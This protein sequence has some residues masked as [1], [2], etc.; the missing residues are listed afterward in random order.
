M[1]INSRLGTAQ[2]CALFV[3]LALIAVPAM[4]DNLISTQSGDWGAGATWGGSV[5]GPTDDVFIASGH[6]V[7]NNGLDTIHINSLSVSGILAHA[8]NS[9]T[10][11]NKIIL[12]ITNDCT[13][14]SGGKIDVTGLGYDVGYGPGVPS[15]SYAG[16]SYGGRGGYNGN[17]E[18]QLGE[19]YGSLVAPTN[20]GSGSYTWG[21]SGG[22]AV[23]ITAG[24][25]T[26]VDGGILANGAAEAV[27]PS[28]SYG[29]GSGGSVFITTA[30]LAGSGSV[31]ANGGKGVLAST[32]GAGGGGRVS[33]VLTSG[34][35]FGSVDLR[36]DRGAGT[37]DTGG[38]LGYS[39][40]GTVYTKT[41]SQPY[42]TVKVD[43]SGKGLF[44]PGGY[45][46]PGTRIPAG[47]TWQVDSV[48]LVNGGT[49]WIDDTCTLIVTNTS[50]STTNGY[51][52]NE[53]TLSVPGDFTLTSVT[54]MPLRGSTF[55][56]T[57]LTIDSSA[58]VSHIKNSTAEDWTLEL[59]VPGNLTIPGGASIDVD[60]VGYRHLQGP[61]R[62]VEVSPGY[63][64]GGSYG[65]RGGIG[66]NGYETGPTYGSISSPTNIGSGGG[67]YIGICN[68]G[69]AIKLTVGGTTSLDGTI[70]ADGVNIDANSSGGG[71][72]GSVWLTT[73]NLVG[74]G[75]ITADGGPGVT[76]GTGGAGGGGGRISVVLTGSDTFGSVALHAYGGVYPTASDLYDGAAGT[77]YKQTQNQVSGRG[78][79]I[80]DNRGELSRRN[81]DISSNV[82]DTVVGDVQFSNGATFDV[83]TN[84]SITVYGNWSN[85]YEF[86]ADAGGTVNLA[87]TNT[88]TVFGHT[89]FDTLICSNVS[90]RIN[91]QAGYTQ[92]VDN[93]FTFSGPSDTGL[94]LRS[95]AA[96][97]WG[98]DLDAG[99][100]QTIEYVDVEYSDARPG[101]AATAANSKDSGS[102]SNWVFSAGGVE[103]NIWIGAGGDSDWGNSGNWILGRS[104]LPADER[105]IISNGVYQPHMPSA[106]TFNNLEVWT[107]ATLSL[108]NFNLTV[109]NEAIV[110]GTITAAGGE[111]MTFS[112]NLT[113]SGTLTAVGSQEIYVGGDI[114]FTGGTFTEASSHVILNGTVAQSITSDGDS[115]ATL[116]ASNQSALVTFVD[117]VTATTYYSR[118]GDV[119]YGGNFDAT[120]F[121]VYSEAG[122]VTHTFEGGSTYTFQEMWLRG[123][124][125]KTQHLESAGT[126]NLNV[127]SVANVNNVNVEYSDA[128]TGIEIVGVNSTDGNNNNNWNFGPFA[129]WTGPGTDFHTASNWEPEVV[130]GASSDIV[131]DDADTCNVDSPAT[132][133]SA[134][135]GGVNASRLQIDN[136]FT[137]VSNVYVVANGTLEINDDPG[138]T[139][140][141][142]MTVSSGG[143]VAHKDNESTEE[144]RM[145]LTV[146]GD[147]TIA[148]GGKIDVTGLG[149]DVG[150]GPGVPSIPYAGGS[151]GGRGGY[152]SSTEVQLGETY[153]SLVAPT[154][155][156]SGS[157]TLG[158]SGGGAIRI[159]V[160]GT[161]TVNGGILANGAVTGE[162]TDPYGGGS[163]GSVFITTANF[164]GSG[165]VTANGALGAYANT[166]GA[167]GGG[168]VAVVLTSGST[169]GSVL[170]TADRGAGTNNTGG[171][172]AYSCAGTVYTKTPSQ[173]YGTVKVDNSGKGL[174]NPGGYL[175]PGT[176]IPAGDTWQVDS[177]ELV[178][179]GTLWIDDT[180]TLIVTNTSPSTTNGYLINEGTL[181]VPGDFVV[182]SVTLM[183][184]AGSVFSGLTN[185]TIDSSAVV[186]H[187]KNS[188]AEDWTLEM[189][190]PGNLTIPGGASID[191]DGLGYDKG[192][193][194]GKLVPGTPGY[195]TGASHGGRG[196][197]GNDSYEPGPT[198][199][200]IRSPT[201]IG[202]GGGYWTVGICNGGGAIKLTVGGTTSLDGTISAKGV[203]IDGNS[204]GGGS[205][206]SVWLTTSSLVGSGTIAADGGPG[207]TVGTGGAGGGGGRISVVL[208]G[209]D[210]FGSA[211]L[212]AYG[213]VYPT[214]SDLFDGAAGTVYKQTLSQGAG[215]GT[216]IVDNNGEV[217]RRS[218]YAPPETNAVADELIQAMIIVTNDNS[219]LT[220]STNI[221]VDDILVYTNADLVLGVYTMYVNSVEHHIDDISQSGAGGPTNGVDSYDQIVWQGA[222]PGMVIVVR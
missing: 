160:G 94:V 200:S 216:L 59:D 193:G 85:G 192:K 79:L 122:A 118:N 126:W 182:S 146:E 110:Q 8:D 148:A 129:V 176:R 188:T 186:S 141:N 136:A 167:G 162:D 11:A 120:M 163:G 123:T 103:T 97:H 3:S 159:T 100:V 19:T 43:N 116:T 180:S 21:T 72:G 115:F 203:N 93:V 220:L 77:I 113:V 221:W 101:T 124:S 121:D 222:A 107:G 64:S 152:N 209:S 42:G 111:T 40:A 131:V 17:T 60:G 33:V 15:I 48:E 39:C 194:P 6:A 65:G 71:S 62:L 98:L 144:N 57:N 12:D 149:Y 24:G 135:I 30:N 171:S 34:S 173:A 196:G 112:S 75:T 183:P 41:P 170:L 106:Q 67:Y 137:V 20:C 205:G 10:E 80:I 161:M 92:S 45:L 164:G 32:H 90:K 47:D 63:R 4:A 154:N 140:S 199:G 190:I 169:F 38:S 99:V 53:G 127:S 73:S 181:S 151:Y 36:A 102:N 87:G 212:Q 58:M 51:L 172:L 84:Q 37:A 119:T 18:V 166:H 150:K 31:T 189:D 56:G 185:L 156:G 145:I 158:T 198:Y 210:N 130:P 215:G 153:G 69:G 13:I 22:G 68:G 208:T 109:N 89:T 211:A 143:I 91:F 83:N 217:S 104:P 142:D 5:P 28:Q 213:G 54:L 179:G 132:V 147:C 2:F 61:G 168:R 218:T 27:V 201:N 206:G 9:S 175:T 219:E 16:G 125:G 86:V 82:I 184:L 70:T 178:N 197:L 134:R 96:A 138:M 55:D 50:P 105:V 155:C 25:T 207:E 29:G 195:R 157:V 204:T 81:T 76:V 52:I 74:S 133:R 88:V 1:H 117:A 23:Q 174:F 108:S 49:L 78:T 66:M 202:S 139:V 46:T 128:G 26:T 165:S 95:T 35:T 114:D 214:A 177:L 14:A 44:N 187:I 7:T 191:V